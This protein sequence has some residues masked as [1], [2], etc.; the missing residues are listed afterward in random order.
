MSGRLLT[1][2]VLWGVGP[3]ILLTFML[4]FQA[5]SYQYWGD[6]YHSVLSSQYLFSFVG[7]GSPLG[8]LWREDRLGGNLWLVSL[9]TV[10]FMADTLLTRL[11]H[12]SPVG[13]DL[14]SNL[15]GY[16]VAAGA[17]YLYLR[18]VLAVSVESAATAAAF[19]T[20]S[21]Y[22][23]SVWTGCANDF[24][25][26]G[27]LPALLLLAHR[28]QAAA[29]AGCGR[30]L[31]SLWVGL[32]FL[33]YVSAAASSLK[34]L[35]ILLALV[36]AYAIF[37]FRAVRPVLFVAS[38]VTTGLVLYSPWLWLLWD[39][40][41]ISQRVV[42]AFVPPA[43][44]DAQQLVSQMVVVLRRVVSG[45]T[46]Y[47][48]TMPMML[49]V[50][51]SL[52]GYREVLKRE[53][54][55]AKPI[56]FFSVVAFVGCFAMDAFAVQ[57]NDLKKTWSYVNGFDVARFQWFVSFFG[58]VPVAWVL[59]R[60]VGAAAA[61]TD[62]PARA[63]LARAAVVVMAGLGTAQAAHIA[64][65]TIALPFSI[66][67]QDLVLDLYLV[68]FLVTSASVLVLTYRAISGWSSSSRRWWFA[69]LSLS[70]LF[71]AS[72]LGYRHG[73]DSAR[74]TAGDE[75]IMSYA[76][77][78]AVPDD[79]ALLKQVNSSDDRVVDLT[80][81]YDRVLSTAAS[82]VL[83]LAGLRTPVGYENLFPRWYD[84][85]IMRAVNGVDGKPSRWVEIRG[86][87]G[88][89][90]AALQLLDVKY[91]LAPVSADI[92]G[93]V[94][95]R[96]HD[97]TGKAIFVAQPEVGPAFLSSGRHCASSD[98]EALAAI[99]AAD[100]A[101]L[102]RR[103]VL[104]STDAVA[105]DLCNNAEEVDSRTDALPARLDVS[106]GRDRVIIEVVSETGGILT[107]A[108]VYYPGWRA[109]VDGVETPILRTYTTLRGVVVNAGRHRVEFIFSP[110]TFWALFRMSSGLLALLLSLVGG[111]YWVSLRAPSQQTTKGTDV[112]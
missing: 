36:M 41:R 92:R 80:R 19:F 17:M 16:A 20:A 45:F 11:L 104:V 65:R 63:K 94:P 30:R 3:F 28:V 66:Y 18:R 54:A 21:G 84:R 1:L 14:V 72:V 39:A 58:L 85:F 59:D 33:M 40:A 26:T 68:L 62:S 73:V 81:P 9:G 69:L 89:N 71:E 47:G 97:P 51:V 103:A 6:K 64:L 25:T 60:G 15:L 23:L 110:G 37:V 31:V 78:F 82:T 95:W 61:S 101:K 46:V 52:L 91:V 90:F 34:T 7:D 108:D 74:R 109:F 8:P 13:I 50:L 10:P 102:V 98:E 43:S 67:P 38:S 56:L 79:I 22:I 93:Y 24:S 88:T 5:D 96:R 106:R 12:L 75:P 4:V 99:H 87:P 100:Y 57:V 111:V 86:G 44:Y 77:R 83:P 48:V 105:R 42:S 35:P 70:V 2:M 53:F 32:A 76:E 27:L 55:S 112:S 29:E 107:L 49:V